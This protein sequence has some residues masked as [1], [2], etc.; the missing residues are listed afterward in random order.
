MNKKYGS[1]KDI[2]LTTK[3]E[4]NVTTFPNAIKSEINLHIKCHE[5]D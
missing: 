5:K 2:T 4:R 3:N 1:S